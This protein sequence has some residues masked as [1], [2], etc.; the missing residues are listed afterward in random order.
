MPLNILLADDSVPAQNMGKKILTDAGYHV[1]AVSNGLEALRKIAEITP[2][3][4]I[5]DIFMPGY[6]GLEI[7]ERLRANVATASLPVILTVGKLEPYRP[8][9]GEQVHSNAVIVKPFAAAELISAVRSLIGAPEAAAES[10]PQLGV[11]RHAADAGADPLQEN[12]TDGQ[13]AQD[14]AGAWQEEGPD[15]PLFSVGP[16]ATRQDESP[17]APSEPT[18]HIDESFISNLEIDEP[19]SLA[20]NPDAKHTPFRASAIDLVA[21]HSAA[22]DDASGFTEFDLE[23]A[24]S[25]DFAA[26][27]EEFADVDESSRTAPA[28]VADAEPDISP[29]P[30]FVVDSALG[31]APELEAPDNFLYAPALDS[32]LEVHEVSASTVEPSLT[33]LGAG[34]ASNAT[35][36]EIDAATLEGVPTGPTAVLIQEQEQEEE[37]RRQAFEVLFNSPQPFADESSPIEFAGSSIAIL[38]SMADLSENHPFD[39]TPDSEIESLIDNNRSEFISPEPDPYLMQEQ[40]P[41][42][43]IPERDPLLEESETSWSEPAGAAQPAESILKAA[44][45]LS[46]PQAEELSELTAQ[47]PCD[48]LVDETHLTVEAHAKEPEVLA[49]EYPSEV[50]PTAFEAATGHTQFVSELLQTTLEASVAHPQLVSDVLPSMATNATPEQ[51]MNLDDAEPAAVQSESTE[52]Q[53]EMHLAEN[54]PEDSLQSI[55]AER[56]REA[57]DKVFDRFK[58][59]LVAAIVRE[60]ARPN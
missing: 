9:D 20:F 57:V 29:S 11:D 32:R 8:Q 58:R 60:L 4:A 5:L 50:V 7:C 59:L 46:S 51:L 21:S 25:H 19:E 41:A 49:P 43:P 56:I 33:I 37:E 34:D 53:T 27:A 12:L 24:P 3:I 40:E 23:P 52:P 10:N 30:V 31:E 28:A 38:P 22:R 14:Q 35:Y 45:E 55:E 47:S 1:L 36:S 42:G 15:E 17:L 48:A 6:T 54:A 13:P 2:D 18:A 39:V 44:G 26:A 16:S